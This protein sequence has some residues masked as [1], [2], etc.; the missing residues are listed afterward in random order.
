MKKIFI[1]VF[2]LLLTGNAM[3]LDNEPEVGI[4]TTTFLGLN[5]TS[6]SNTPYSTKAGGV[7]GVKFD[8]VL[9]NAHGT[10]I[11]TGVDWTLKG[12][13]Y[14]TS[15]ITL[16]GTPKTS[17]VTIKNRMNYLE[18]PVRVGFRYNLNKEFGFYGEFGPYFAIGFAGRHAIRAEQENKTWTEY[19]DTHSYNIFRSST[20]KENYQR[21]DSGLGFRLGAEY[22]QHYNV[23]LGCDWGI[24]DMYRKAYRTTEATYTGIKMPKAHNFNFTLAL[25]YRF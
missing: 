4:T 2:G 12:G 10:Y 25:G 20:E 21:W 24:T 6:I 11:T 16:E 8:Y 18:I 7:L 23:T 13:K 9:P 17:D 22:N 5:L 3:A 1:T 14:Q 15:A 19:E